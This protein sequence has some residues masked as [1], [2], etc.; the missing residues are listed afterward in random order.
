MEETFNVE[1]IARG[2]H[3]VYLGTL[4]YFARWAN[5]PATRFWWPVL[6]ALHAPAFVAYTEREFGLGGPGGLSVPRYRLAERQF[7]A[8]GLTHVE[9][10]WLDS[11]RPAPMP[12]DTCLHLT[13]ALSWGG[14]AV[15][16]AVAQLVVRALALH[17]APGT[18]GRVAVFDT[19]WLFVPP[20]LWGAGAGSA[21][22]SLC[23]VRRDDALAWATGLLVRVPLVPRHDVASRR[24]H[25]A[26][27]QFYRAQGFTDV[28]PGPGP[29]GEF[30]LRSPHPA[31]AVAPPDPLGDGDDAWR[32]MYR[33][34]R[35]SAGEPAAGVPG[36]AAVSAPERG[37]LAPRGAA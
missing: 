24:E 22:L 3:A 13:T 33:E 34:I 4:N 35:P 21:L 14:G 6:R 26:V 29:G 27:A 12:G 20:G 19:R 17:T 18:P 25:A 11:G 16:V 36:P 1:P 30:T 5:L 9:R 7:G 10:C 37:P 28:H 23:A 32:W 15:E 8:G 31:A 2:R